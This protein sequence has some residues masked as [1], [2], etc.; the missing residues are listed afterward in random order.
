MLTVVAVLVAI[1]SIFLAYRGLCVLKLRR[2]LWSIYGVGHQ[3][4][5]RTGECIRIF[6]AAQ[7][8]ARE[9]GWETEEQTFAAVM[10]RYYSALLRKARRQPSFGTSV[11]VTTQMKRSQAIL[12]GDKVA[13]AEADKEYD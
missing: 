13:L 3:M 5:V 12:N 10:H 1:V 4:G 6:N 9:A 8:A 2:E 7:K 11:F